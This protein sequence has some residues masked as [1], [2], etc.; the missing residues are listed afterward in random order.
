MTVCHPIR[1]KRSPIYFCDAIADD[2]GLVALIKEANAFARSRFARAAP[3]GDSKRVRSRAAVADERLPR[4]ISSLETNRGHRRRSREMFLETLPSDTCSYGRTTCG[5]Y[6][7]T[8]NC[9]EEINTVAR[10]AD[11]VP[12][13]QIAF[14]FPLLMPSAAVETVGRIIAA[15]PIPFSRVR[16]RSVFLPCVLLGSAL[17]IF[18]IN[19]WINRM[20]VIV[21]PG[22]C[23]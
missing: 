22:H 11:V 21:D 2:F 4:T 3:I 8:A 10:L 16:G 20:T 14:A 23:R 17:E 5:D 7:R 15:I 13:A 19:A 6:S 18:W 9:C 1:P 12:S